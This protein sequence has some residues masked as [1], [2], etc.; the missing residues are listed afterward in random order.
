M[1]RMSC[2][3]A[4]Q[5]GRFTRCVLALCS[6]LFLAATSTILAATANAYSSDPVWSA[7]LDDDLRF[8]QTT[9]MGVLIAGTEKSLYAVDSESGEVLWRRR[10]MR[11][12]QTD[13]APV[14]GTDLLLLSYEESGRSRMEAVDIMTG[15]PLWRS[16]KVKG[17]IMHLAVDPEY[18]LVALVLV[19]DTKGRVSGGIKTPAYNSSVEPRRRKRALEA[20]A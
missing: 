14:V 10:N 3:G 15:N 17:S 13:L 18:E 9:E 19:R 20:G 4:Q 11:V 2:I 1:S 12:D 8:Y 6:L 16:D 7:K 5:A